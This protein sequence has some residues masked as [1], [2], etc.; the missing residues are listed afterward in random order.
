[1]ACTFLVSRCMGPR[2]R[3]ALRTHEHRPS[4]LAPST[5]GPTTGRAAKQ[6]GPMASD[7]SKRQNTHQKLQRALSV[8][9]ESVPHAAAGSLNPTPLSSVAVHGRQSRPHL[10]S[11]DSYIWTDDAPML[12]FLSTLQTRQARQ[13]AC[14]CSPD[15][16][17]LPPSYSLSQYV[18]AS[19]FQRPQNPSRLQRRNLHLQLCSTDH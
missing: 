15:F 19:A 12:H 11:E 2:G 3:G 4:A 16:S 7:S 14:N 10:Q 8:H 17:S 13:P 5:S 18:S 1:M 9:H 6:R